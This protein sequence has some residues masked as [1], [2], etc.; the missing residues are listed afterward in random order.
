MATLILITLCAAAALLIYRAA[1]RP[2]LEALVP[3]W[4]S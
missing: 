3:G 1:V 2:V 4:L